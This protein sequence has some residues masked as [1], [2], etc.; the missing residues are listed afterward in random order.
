MKMLLE[1][2]VAEILRCSTSKVKRLRLDGK[3]PYLKGRPVLIRPEDLDAYLTSITRTELVAEQVCSPQ[4][5]S[6][7]NAP[8]I[9]NARQWAMEQLLLPR[10]KRK[11][12]LQ[13][14]KTDTKS[15]AAE[16]TKR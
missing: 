7:K 13:P 12:P 15:R 2:E 5:S 14:R 1:T 3:L 9:A 8:D 16:P 11:Q 4:L 10:G 6:T